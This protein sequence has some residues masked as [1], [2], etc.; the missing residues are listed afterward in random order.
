[1]LVAWWRRSDATQADLQQCLARQLFLKVNDGLWPHSIYE[2]A[3]ENDFQASLRWS[4]CWIVLQVRCHSNRWHDF[5]NGG[6]SA[7]PEL[8]WRAVATIQPHWNWKVKQLYR[9][10]R[11]R[12]LI[13]L[14][15]EIFHF[16][17]NT[18]HPKQLAGSFLK[19]R[20][21]RFLEVRALFK[22]WPK[23]IFD[24]VWLWNLACHFWSCN[25]HF[26]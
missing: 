1:M 14:R 6:T 21:R 20:K 15:K 7:V 12:L 26:A 16:N 17:E 13:H 5:H 22:P 2:P 23:S 10:I 24:L 9:I 3:L 18:N 8:L 25:Y 11:R 19:Q 4:R